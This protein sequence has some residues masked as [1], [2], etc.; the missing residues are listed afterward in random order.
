MGR[1]ARAAAFLDRDGVINVDHGYIHRPEDFELLPGT[2]EALRQLKA[3]GY[4]LII[5]TNQ[6]GIGR[7]YYSESDLAALHG[8][9]KELL[10]REGVKLDAI[11]YCPHRPDE[12]CSCRKPLPGLI[13]R[14]LDELAVD[15]SR[16]FIVGDKPSDIAAGA[17]GGLGTAYLLSDE[18]EFATLSE[19][20]AAHIAKVCHGGRGSAKS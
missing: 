4:L 15:A 16:S 18:G 8:H 1:I 9:M 13:Q 19:C 6:S 7:G 5:V 17:A 2:L 10:A 12:R 11:Y 14:A 3:A 20:V